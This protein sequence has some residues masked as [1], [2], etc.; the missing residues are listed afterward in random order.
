MFEDF[1][2]A[3]MG[4]TPFVNTSRNSTKSSSGNM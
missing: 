1:A 4:L 3:E 2:A